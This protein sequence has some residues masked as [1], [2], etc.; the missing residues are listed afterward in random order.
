MQ[1]EDYKRIP[2]RMMNYAKITYTSTVHLYRGSS[3][4]SLLY[5]RG[6]TG[7]CTEGVHTRTKERR[8]FPQPWSVF[9]LSSAIGSGTNCLDNNAS[10]AERSNYR[11]KVIEEGE[12][13]NS[14]TTWEKCK[15]LNLLVHN[16]ETKFWQTQ[17]GPS[18]CTSLRW[19]NAL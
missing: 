6:W 8:T 4:R 16:T 18:L 3:T 10:E 9:N 12:S 7:N 15:I 13:S 2:Q 17:S 19:K 5:C 14:L 11:Y 1:S